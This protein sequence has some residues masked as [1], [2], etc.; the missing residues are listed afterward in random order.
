MNT[1]FATFNVNGLNADAKRKTI[2]NYL[3]QKNFEIILLQETHST[4]KVEKLWEMEWGNKIE[5][6]HGTNRSKGLAI[7]LKNN[8]NYDLIK[9]YQDPHGRF[10]FLEI[11]V[12]NSCLTIANI[13]GPNVD[14][15]DFFRNMFVK[16][17]D[18]SKNEI[19][20][21]EDFNVILNNDLDK[22]NGSPHKNKL[23]RQEILLH[24]KFEL[25]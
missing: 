6:L 25:N 2:F 23:A 8:L 20:M 21:G 24:E 9:T 18:F 14:D 16:L 13:Y 12:K 3:K 7:L 4:E 10:L 17:N 19:L 22:L 15:F 5:W 1:L 11:K